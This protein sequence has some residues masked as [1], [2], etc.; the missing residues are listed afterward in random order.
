MRKWIDWEDVIMKGCFVL[1]VSLL[2]FLLVLL[3]MEIRNDLWASGLE[4]READAVV[5]SAEPYEEVITR[6]LY[7]NN[8]FVGFSPAGTEEGVRLTVETEDGTRYEIETESGFVCEKGDSLLIEIGFE[9][10]EPTDVARLKEK[11]EE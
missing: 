6:P 5:I 9:D 10:G 3:V 8:R 7:I 4:Y 11:Q 1:L 2:A